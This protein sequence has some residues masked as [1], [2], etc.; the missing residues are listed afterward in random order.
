LAVSSCSAHDAGLFPGGRSF[1][2]QVRF[3]SASGFAIL[4]LLLVAVVLSSLLMLF[5]CGE[6]FSRRE[7]LSATDTSGI[8][9]ATPA[10]RRVAYCLPTAV[11]GTRDYL[12]EYYDGCP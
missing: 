5:A 9:D 10:L 2:I 3:F 8:T 12:G 1:S 4:L 11:S 7:L 6:F